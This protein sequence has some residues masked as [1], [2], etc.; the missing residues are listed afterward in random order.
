MGSYVTV[1]GD[2][3]DIISYNLFGNEN[4]TGDIIQ[5]NLEYADIVVF[6][7]GIIL[8]IPEIAVE[9]YGIPPWRDNIDRDTDEDEG[10][11]DGCEEDGD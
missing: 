10:F 1:S 11:Y 5:A 4:Y 7:A 2:Q 9:N 3:W 6:P 8:N